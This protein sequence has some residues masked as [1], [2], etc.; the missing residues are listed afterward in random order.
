MAKH[1]KRTKTVLKRS[2]QIKSVS[3]KA[4]LKQFTK[5]ARTNLK[6]HVPPAEEKKELGK[7][8]QKNYDQSLALI[9]TLIK[10]PEYMTA[11]T[12]LF[13]DIS[14]QETT[15]NRRVQ[16]VYTFLQSIDSPDFRDMSLS[17]FR[18]VYLASDY[19]AFVE[20]Y[21]EADLTKYN[22]Q[23]KNLGIDS[24]QRALLISH[25]FFGSL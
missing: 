24:Q 25:K 18:E 22:E 6:S 10:D 23:L 9:D 7:R 19:R 12:K 20:K 21:L 8:A 14:S 5:A 11:A 17:D 15:V 4:N 1:S 3:S 2:K 13:Q 16:A